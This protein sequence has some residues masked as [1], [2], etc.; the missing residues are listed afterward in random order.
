VFRGD[1]EAALRIAETLTDIV[2]KA[3]NPLNSGSAKAFR[4]WARARLDP[5]ATLEEFRQVVLVELAEQSRVGMPL[6]KGL[7]AELEADAGTTD[8]G[9]RGIDESLA[10]QSARKRPPGSA[11]KRDPLATDRGG[12]ARPGEA[13]WGCAAGASADR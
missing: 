9:L 1:A 12:S 11:S 2:E 4:G 10:C 3:G 13:G 8:A 7:L 5:A 6:F